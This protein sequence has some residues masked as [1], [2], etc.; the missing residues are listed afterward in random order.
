GSQR[1][2]GKTIIVKHHGQYST[3]YAHMSR[4]AP[5]MKKGQKVAQGQTIGYV[6]AT[7][8]ATGPH[9]HYEFR[10]AGKQVDPQSADLP[11]ARSLEGESL[12]K[13]KQH[14][15]AYRSQLEMLAQLQAAQESVLASE[16]IVAAADADAS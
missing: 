2:Y 6:G 9:L 5:Q 13:F 4:F 11:I 15:A 12:A 1:G 14:V 3:L 7:G 10:I 8:M 16:D